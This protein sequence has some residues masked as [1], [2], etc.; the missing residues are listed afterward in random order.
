V[1][2]ANHLREINDDRFA[3]IATNEDVE[4]VEVTVYESRMGEPDDEIHQLRVEFTRR[5][6]MV[7]LTPL[8]PCY[9][10]GCI[11]RH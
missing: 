1:R 3:V 5:R 9:M 7:D 10:S 8:R 2:S 11:N 4:F 6:Y